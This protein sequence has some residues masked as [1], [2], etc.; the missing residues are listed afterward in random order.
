MHVLMYMSRF[1]RDCVVISAWAGYCNWVTD[2]QKQMRRYR[3]HSI[4]AIIIALKTPGFLYENGTTGCSL[5]EGSPRM[6]CPFLSL[7]DACID[8]QSETV[9]ALF[10][11]PSPFFYVYHDLHDIG[12]LD[13][14]YSISHAHSIHRPPPLP[15]PSLPYFPR[16]SSLTPD[17][18]SLLPL[19]HPI[20]V[21]TR[22]W[23]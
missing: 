7:F 1:A 19:T 10:L 22:W 17:S 3:T 6:I 13:A 21:C 20:S 8:M 23:M 9:Q 15:S 16:P 14:D 2:P 18:L 11:S 5:F 12:G 4:H